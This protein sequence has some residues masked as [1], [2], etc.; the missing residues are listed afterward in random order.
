[1]VDLS[2]AALVFPAE[3]APAM[4]PSFAFQATRCPTMN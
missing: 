3:P 2:L 4:V 1:M